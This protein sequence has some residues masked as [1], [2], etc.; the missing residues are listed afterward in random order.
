MK[1]L[2]DLEKRIAEYSD[3]FD[4]EEAKVI[5]KR[6]QNAG[7]DEVFNSMS[8]KEL[9]EFAGTDP[10]K[11]RMA[12]S[13]MAKRNKSMRPES[14]LMASDYKDPK[15]IELDIQSELMEAFK[16]SY[17]RLK[18]QGYGG[19][20]MDYI[21]D[22]IKLQ[23]GLKLAR[24]GVVKDPTFNIYANGGP[25]QDLNKRDKLNEILLSSAM[26]KISDAMSGIGG[27]LM[28][29]KLSGGGPSNKPKQP[30]APKE[31]NLADYFRYGATV[32]DLTDSEREQVNAL[33][34]KMLSNKQDN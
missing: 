7:A 31:I 15:E 12:R 1:A 18:E 17:E 9:K 5:R 4:E 28:R 19:S 27:Q 30:V 34:K 10:A 24:G 8:T 2:N 20:F 14:R 22:E 13:I 16:E 3:T 6:V 29:Q 25:V 32:A 33:L 21:K 23:R 11:I 26:T